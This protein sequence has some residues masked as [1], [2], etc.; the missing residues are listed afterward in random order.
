VSLD[1]QSK[2]KHK[3]HHNAIEG[4]CHDYAL[5]RMQ[6]LQFMI[7][8]FFFSCI[9]QPERVVVPVTAKNPYH[10]DV[11]GQERQSQRDCQ[12]TSNGDSTSSI[13]D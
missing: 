7:M 4:M 8:V 1:E 12:S 11:K 10:V 2:V 6:L 13:V 5:F 9:I 3:T